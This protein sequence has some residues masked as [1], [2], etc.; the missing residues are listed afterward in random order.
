MTT[1]NP[2]YYNFSFNETYEIQ[3]IE[4]FFNIKMVWQFGFQAKK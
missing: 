3:Y 4:M 2:K 1:L